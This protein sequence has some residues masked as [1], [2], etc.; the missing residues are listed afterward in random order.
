MEWEVVSV[1]GRLALCI[2]L[3]ALAASTATADPLVFRP[4]PSD[5]VLHNPHMGFQTFQRFNGDPLYARMWSEV[6]PTEFGPPPP[7]LENE[8][9]P[10]TSVAYCRWYWDTIEPDD[11]VY[12]W[13]II[14]AALA[15][16]RERG[17]TLAIR[18]MCHDSAGRH[19]VP[20][21]F[22]ETGARGGTRRVG[23]G[24]GMRYWVPDY[25]DPLYVKYWTR[26]SEA[27]AERY[28]GHVDLESVDIASIGPWGEW[29]TKPV[30]PPMAVKAALVDCYTDNF[31]KTPLLMQFDDAPSLAHAVAQGTGWRADCLGDM[32]HWG[33]E[34]CHMLDFYPRGIAYGRAT[35]AW[36]RAPVAFEVCD[37]MG[38]WYERDWDVDYVFDEA[39]KWH[40]TY[41][42]AKSSPLPEAYDERVEKLLKRIGYR[43]RLR[44]FASAPAVKSGGEMRFNTWWENTGCAPIYRRYDLAIRLQSE[45]GVVVMETDADITTW[46]PGDIIYDSAVVVPEGLPPGRYALSVGL[47]DPLT[48][49]PKIRLAQEGR[50]DDGWYSLG[51]IDVAARGDEIEQF[52]ERGAP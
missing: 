16:A 49:K 19:D 11:G 30:D 8:N 38:S 24:R 1:K 50:N 45:E 17:Q 14:D 36:K 10:E 2:A 6:G 32:G 48:G 29:S 21:W 26:L 37:V 20:E 9:Y 43:F 23:R 12:R 46:L 47:L 4:K 34:W 15:T 13:E 42:N 3:A 40:T 41:I 22:R 18:V 51:E 7:S 28:D 31:K 5:E 52:A 39:V 25:S 27:L 35:D 33:P 44:R